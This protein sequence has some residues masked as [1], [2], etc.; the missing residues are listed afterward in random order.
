MPKQKNIDAV[1]RL[2]DKVSRAKGIYLTDYRGLTHKQLENLHKNVKK[3][4][5]EYV[6]V[7]NSLL[8]LSLGS[9]FTVKKVHSNEN[10]TVNS[11]P[12]LTINL[13]GPTG[14]LF[15]YADEINPL[16]ELFKFIK[17]TTLPKVKAGLVGE[18][19]YDESQVA[20]LSKLP[21]KEVLRGQVVSR[22]SGPMYGLVYALNG[23]LNKLAYILNNIKK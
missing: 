14:V 8:K 2:K 16:K 11:E 22:L 19:V 20:T 17:T 15:S 13:T 12:G 4:D 3:A 23:N 5:G 18:N 9:Q 10:S 1:A 21:T 7:K 6:V